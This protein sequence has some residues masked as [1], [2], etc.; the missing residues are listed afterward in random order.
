MYLYLCM[1]VHIYLYIYIYT[2]IICIAIVYGVCVYRCATEACTHRALSV[3]FCR[4]EA[5]A[6]TSFSTTC[7]IV[8]Y[9]SGGT[10]CL[11]LLV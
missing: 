11:T 7:D 8:E 1:Y 6:A 10:T 5:M 9:Y 2:C 3:A 4:F